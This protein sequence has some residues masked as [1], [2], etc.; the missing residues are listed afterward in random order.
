[1]ATI[2]T[3]ATRSMKREGAP[4]EEVLDDRALLEDLEQA[5]NRIAERKLK[6]SPGKIQQKKIR[7]QS[8]SEN[9]DD[10]SGEQESY[11]SE[12]N[13]F[14]ANEDEVEDELRAHYLKKEAKRSHKE[15]K[16]KKKHIRQLEDE[17]FDLIKENAGITVTKKNRLKRNREIE[18]DAMAG[19]E[20]PAVKEE[21]QHVR[22]TQM[23]QQKYKH[24]EIAAKY[25]PPIAE[26]KKRQRLELEDSGHHRK[27]D[28]AHKIFGD[29]ED[30]QRADA[31]QVAKDKPSNLKEFF[32]TDEIDDPFNTEQDQKIAEIDIP[33]RLQVKL[34]N[35][36]QVSASDLSQEAD[37]VLERLTTIPDADNKLGKIAHAQGTKEK[38]LKVLK[39]FHDDLYDIP[40]IVKYRKYE[41]AVE[42]DEDAVWHVWN[43]D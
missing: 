39:M 2:K 23:L 22:P 16:A 10:E 15:K 27:Q 17:D 42:L 21:V 7:R 29:R 18:D 40:M 37:W 28:K 9:D 33:E 26:L 3:R 34:E 30:T 20:E 14:I 11:G 4:A 25:E 43:L 35:R 38:V 32:N 36:L 6:K 12:M 1:M 8:Q 5:E 31:H 41:Y 19:K 24:E 13:D